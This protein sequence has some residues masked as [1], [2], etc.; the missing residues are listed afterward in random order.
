MKL[1]EALRYKPEGR[2]CMALGVYSDSNRN[3]RQEYFLRGKSGLWLTT[4]PLSCANCLKIC[5]S[6]PP[7]TLISR[8]G[9]QR[10]CFTLPL[11][12]LQIFF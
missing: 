12:V 2:G 10:D 5:Y 1:V 3:D 7:D 11:L 6:Q 8:P 9:L 4:L